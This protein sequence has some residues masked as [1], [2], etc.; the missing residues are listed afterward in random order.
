MFKLQPPDTYRCENQVSKYCRLIEEHTINFKGKNVCVACYSKLVELDDWSEKFLGEHRQMRYELI[1]IHDMRVPEFKL[2]F[3]ISKMNSMNKFETYMIGK[4]MKLEEDNHPSTH[5]FYE[6]SIEFRYNDT[7]IEFSKRL[8]VVKHEPC[9]SSIPPC[10]MHDCVL[11]ECFCKRELMKQL[12]C[13]CYH[14]N[15]QR[16]TVPPKVSD[17]VMDS[18][19]LALK[20]YAESPVERQ[21]F[22]GA[23]KLYDM[24][25]EKIKSCG[26]CSKPVIDHD[27][28][29][30]VVSYENENDGLIGYIIPPYSEPEY[31]KNEHGLMELVRAGTHAWN[32]CSS[33]KIRK[34]IGEM[35][36]DL[37]EGK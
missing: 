24:V 18:L 33:F 32:P 4:K 12:Q 17:D 34:N 1:P 23:E 10:K 30:M 8:G 31:R 25:H 15:L 22:M 27:I 20:A 6:S 9:D 29:L 14:C 2:E 21:V 5:I 28:A 26:H 13:P 3:H 7:H 37:T 16:V 19:V 11:D 35:L 36:Q